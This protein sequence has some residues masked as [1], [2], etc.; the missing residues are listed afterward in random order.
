MHHSSTL[1]TL[2]FSSQSPPSNGVVRPRHTKGLEPDVGRSLTLGAIGGLVGGNVRGSTPSSEARAG[3]GGGRTGAVPVALGEVEARRRGV[4]SMT[5]QGHCCSQHQCR[6]TH[7]G[8]LGSGSL[9]RVCGVCRAVETKRAVQR[10]SGVVAVGSREFTASNS[11]LCAPI[12]RTL[13]HMAGRGKKRVKATE[14]G[15]F[16]DGAEGPNTAIFGGLVLGWVASLRVGAAAFGSQC[17]AAVH[18]GPG[19][20]LFVWPPPSRCSQPSTESA[21]ALHVHARVVNL[22]TM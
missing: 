10:N 5:Q 3:L 20:F 17:F 12:F 16:V 19:L 9:K 6:Q 7:E 22:H 14:E 13:S 4:N 21:S 8:Q 15:A 18:K 11:N 1:A 2:F